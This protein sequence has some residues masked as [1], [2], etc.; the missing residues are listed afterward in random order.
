MAQ[1]IDPIQSLIEYLQD[2]KPYHTK[3]VD[4]N[5]KYVFSEEMDVSVEENHVLQTE[6][7]FDEFQQHGIDT[8]FVESLVFDFGSVIIF[9]DS[10]NVGFCD[11]NQDYEKTLNR[12]TFE[13]ITVNLPITDVNTVDNTFTVEGNQSHRFV[14]TDTFIVSSTTARDS[15]SYEN[16]GTLENSPQWVRGFVATNIGHSLYFDGTDN[17]RVEVGDVL[18]MGTN[19]FTLECVVKTES[20]TGLI[21]KGG[22]GDA[23]W[24]LQVIAGGIISFSLSDGIESTGDVGGL[25]DIRDGIPHHV[26]VVVDRIEG[27]FTVYLDGKHDGEQDI[28]PVTGSLNNTV[29]LRLGISRSLGGESIK[30]LDEVRIWDHKRTKHQIQENMN[31][32]L[33]P[34]T[35]GLIGYWRFDE[36]SG[37]TVFDKSI[38]SNDGTLILGP[39]FDSPLVGKTMG[40]A[41]RFDGVNQNVRVATPPELEIVGDLT[42]E[43]WIKPSSNYTWGNGGIIT[44]GIGTDM[45]Y[46]MVYRPASQTVSFLWNDGT[47]K[48]VDSPANSFP[49]NELNHAAIVRDGTALRI[50]KNGMLIHTGTVTAPTS[51]TT[52]WLDIGHQS[53][54]EQYFAGIIDEAR[55]WNTVRTEQEIYDYKDVT[56]VGDEAGLV[57][58]WNFNNVFT[59]DSVYHDNTV[60]PTETAITT[61]EPIIDTT[62]TNIFVDKVTIRDY[63]LDQDM[64]EVY[65]PGG[66]D[67]CGYNTDFAEELVITIDYT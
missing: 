19:D 7:D 56:L 18:N 44:G 27:I 60:S 50:Y 3:I 40:G 53:G 67:S 32:L 22:A 45:Q 62:A 33:N 58:Y 59:V 51:A 64:I 1:I 34:Y 65:S 5:V 28:S 15:T 13:G 66:Y 11:G 35:S 43:A 10:I 48:N 30:K 21:S 52:T 12:Y 16:H 20:N 41:L 61:I 55:V 46:S 14:P 42:L 25:T 49:W 6:I 38:N 4:V 37:T 63:L 24:Q 31:R 9:S 54:P 26:A 39:V 17:Q 36:G 57:G 2:N 23:W 29:P 8:S 47:Y